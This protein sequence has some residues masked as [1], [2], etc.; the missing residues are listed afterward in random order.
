MKKNILTHRQGITLAEVVV[1]LGIFLLISLAIY[2][3]IKQSYKI[4]DF[5]LEQSIAM[6]EVMTKY[7]GEFLPY[8]VKVT[9]IEQTSFIA[10]LKELVN[11]VVD[12][13]YSAEAFIWFFTH[14]AAMFKDFGA[15]PVRILR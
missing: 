7:A 14:G 12:L 3:F 6:A 8:N 2:T 5:S 11:G 9:T 4:Q 1:A 15:H 13:N 10:G